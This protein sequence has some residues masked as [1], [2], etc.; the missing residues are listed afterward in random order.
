MLTNIKSVLIANRGEIALRIVRACRELGIRSV[1]A[2]SEADAQSLPVREADQ[3]V[4]IGPA[5]ANQSYRNQQT[6]IGAALAYGI[7]AIHPGYGFLSENAEFAAACEKAGVI[8]VGPSSDVIHQ[9]GSKIEARNIAK[10]ADVP[11]IPG[12][13]GAISDPAEARAV[14]KAV[15]F[16]LLIK[17]SAGGGG[18]G[19]RVVP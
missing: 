14:A 19:M 4:C 2:Y 1:V 17:A 11:T 9:M 10:A 16:P 6:I 18:R 13:D 8:F 12:S 7:D 3:A 15:G 5:Q